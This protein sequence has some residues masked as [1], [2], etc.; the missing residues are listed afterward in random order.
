MKERKECPGAS[1][2]LFVPLIKARH[3]QSNHVITSGF[4]D[5]S[6]RHNIDAAT[7]ALALTLKI[8][9]ALIRVG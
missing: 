7:R 4:G 3:P 1:T 9:T 6:Q 8:A 2:H 5:A